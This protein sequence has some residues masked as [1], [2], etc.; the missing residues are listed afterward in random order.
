MNPMTMKIIAMRK[1]TM[2]GGSRMLQIGF[3][4]PTSGTSGLTSGPSGTARNVP[5][6][7]P[8]SGKTIR[9]APLA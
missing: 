4:K 2:T 6:A 1:K 8:M 9:I 3:F 5:S 7:R